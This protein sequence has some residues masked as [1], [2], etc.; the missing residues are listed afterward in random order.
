MSAWTPQDREWAYTSLCEAIN[1]AGE[2]R[3]TLLL[4]RLC[5]LL[6][7]ELADADAFARALA[8]ATLPANGKP[9]QGSRA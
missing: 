7:E 6:T 2:G 4:A 9:S 8:S 5:L 3:E 1:A